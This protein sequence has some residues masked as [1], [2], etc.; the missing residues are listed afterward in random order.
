MIVEKITNI[1]IKDGSIHYNMISETGGYVH[2]AIL[3]EEMCANDWSCPGEGR[4]FLGELEK[5]A[6]EKGLRLIVSNVIN[7]A[8]ETILRKAG[9]EA[10]YIKDPFIDDWMQCWR[11]K[12]MNKDNIKKCKVC[13]GEIDTEYGYSTPLEEKIDP[14]RD[15]LGNLQEDGSTL[16]F[17][18]G[19]FKQ[20]KKEK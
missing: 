12:E 5:Y 1:D 18:L 8:L 20:Y 2:F 19:C 7:P 9:F 10:F 15:W 14:K 13:D 11:K 17:H 3:G 4:R 16:Y 6:D